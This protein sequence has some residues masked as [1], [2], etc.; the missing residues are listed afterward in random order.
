[1]ITMRNRG[2]VVL[3][4]NRDVAMIKRVK[5][6]LTCY[7]FTGGGIEHEETT[8]DTTK[9]E[10]YEELGVHI[11]V[12]N[13]IAKIDYNRDQYYFLGEIIGSTFGTGQG[14][15][16]SYSSNGIYIPMWVDIDDLLTMNVK[17]KEVAEKVHKLMNDVL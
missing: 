13:S 17:P 7:V 5:D 12:K 6:D 3:I 1:G 11:D 2:S 10:D 16:F 8:E 9:R 15:E 4:E 14:E